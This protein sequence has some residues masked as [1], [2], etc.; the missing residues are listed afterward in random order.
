MGH[1]FF[2]LLDIKKKNSELVGWVKP[3]K[4]F[5]FSVDIN[6][7]MIASCSFSSLDFYFIFLGS[8]VISPLK[9]FCF[10]CI[11]TFSIKAKILLIAY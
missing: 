4:D 7:Q 11:V 2:L 5:F 6:L 3:T 9:S 10:S 1:I 8:R